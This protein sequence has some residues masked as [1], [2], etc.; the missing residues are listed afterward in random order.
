M[1]YILLRFNV[2]VENG[3]IN[4]LNNYC[5]KGWR[6]VGNLIILENEIAYQMLEKEVE[7]FL[8][9]TIRELYFKTVRPVRALESE[10]IKYV[11]QLIEKTDKDILR[12]SNVSFHTLRDIKNTL[13]E[14]GLYLRAE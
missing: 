3:F 7:P 6:T 1:E 4:T 8:K 12:M 13:A 10:G 11:Y 9:K 14:H 5:D 2:A